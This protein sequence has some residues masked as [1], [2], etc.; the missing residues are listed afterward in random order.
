MAKIV[1]PTHQ[2]EVINTINNLSTNNAMG[3]NS[4]PMDIFHL[5]KLSIS[6]PLVN[7][8]NLAFEKGS[9][10]ERLGSYLECNNYRPISLLSNLNKIIEKLKHE[11]LFAFLT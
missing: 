6:Q 1:K 10:I 9:Y 11:R 7:I 3:P 5:I 4:I 8:I 2:I